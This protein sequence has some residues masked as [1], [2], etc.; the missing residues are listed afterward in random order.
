MPLT[1]APPQR[2]DLRSILRRF[3]IGDP[4]TCTRLTRGLLNRGYHLVTTRG[5]FFLKHHLGG[6][7]QSVLPVETA[8]RV[9]T[10]LDGADLPVCPPLTDRD[11]K[12]VVLLGDR[13]YAVHPWVPGH[14]LEGAALTL[15]EAHRLGDLL[16]R[17]HLALDRLLPRPIGPLPGLGLEAADPER[18]RRTAERLIARTRQAR[19]RTDF[20]LLAERR[21]RE[22]LVLLDH[23]AGDRPDRSVIPPT[24]WVHG[25][26]HPLNVLYSPEPRVPRGLPPTG[27]GGP[28]GREALA[29]IDWDRLGTGPRAE[30]VVRAA[31]IFFLLPDGTLD[32]PRVRAYARGYRA[33]ADVDADELAAGAHRVWWERLNDF[34]ILRWHYER[35]DPRVDPQL[36]ATSALVPWW[37]RNAAAVRDAFRA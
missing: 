10:A 16:G 19:H 32:L 35:E 26:F 27:R 14:H 36:P 3:D 33:A 25:D 6:D 1:L 12:T 20:D 2:R 29:V 15:H 11:G 23:H 34:W 18:T 31:A 9:V 5:R 7:D 13:S 21:L 30:E 17:L 8:H 4:H 22:R 24:G 28:P 37:S